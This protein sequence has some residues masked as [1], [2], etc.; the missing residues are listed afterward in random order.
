MVKNNS[1]FLYRSILTAVIEKEKVK[2]LPEWF[3]MER[4]A[5]GNYSHLKN[6][7]EKNNLHTICKSGNCPNIGECWN[8]GTATFM[9]LGDICTRACKF[10]SVRTGKPMPVDWDE[11]RRLAESIKTLGVKH[12]VLTSVDRDDLEDGGASFWVETIR[13]VKETNPELTLETLIPDFRGRQDHIQQVIGAGPEVISHNL[14]TVQR[15]TP[16]IRSMNKYE[17]SLDVVRYISSRGFISKSGI[18]LGLGETREEVLETMDDLRAAG[19]KVLTIGQYLQ[20]TLRH[21][22]VREYIHPEVFREYKK[23]GL[24]MGFRFVESSPL[25]RSSYHAERHIN[26]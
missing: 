20:P 5:G 14:E 21:H 4:P 2:R 26:A 3:R 15:L 12:C 11:P 10:C 16:R 6:L 23:I 9:I 13:T 25:V 18:M 7:S 19:C 8:A 17:T 22:P 1:V 24:E